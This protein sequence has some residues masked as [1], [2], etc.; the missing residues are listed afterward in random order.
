MTGH[1]IIFISVSKL[2]YN[3]IFLDFKVV[4]KQLLQL[5]ICWAHVAAKIDEKTKS[6]LREYIEHIKNDF[7]NLQGVCDN[8]HQF[9][10]A[11]K[12]LFIRLLYL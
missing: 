3:H 7:H 1:Q 11:I 6:I 2:T 8:T 9:N 5:I 12:L 4:F 10:K